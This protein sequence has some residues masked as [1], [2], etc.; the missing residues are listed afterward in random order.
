MVIRD[1]EY[2]YNDD[3]IFGVKSLEV[4]EGSLLKIT[5]GGEAG[6]KLWE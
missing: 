4:R 5:V 1:N 6:E 3:L 2:L